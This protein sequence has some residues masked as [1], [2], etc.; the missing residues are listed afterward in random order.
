MKTT[1]QF[2][3]QVGALTMLS[4]ILAFASM[5]VG[6]LAVEFDFDTFA[7][8]SSMLRFSHNHALVKGSMLLDMFGYYLLLTPV[9]FYFHRYLSRKTLWANT[10]TFCG[11]SYIL[12][13]SIGAAILA[14]VWPQQMQ[15]YLT[16]NVAQ[17]AV[18]QA[19]A[20]NIAAIV[21]GGMWNILETFLCG[22]WW[23]GLGV[24]LRTELKSPGNVSI[25]LGVACLLDSVGNM[26]GLKM[27]AE[28]GLNIYL[29]FAIVW[30]MWVGILIYKQKITA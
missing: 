13:G 21:Y 3:R 15:A 4:A 7:D 18:L 16:A 23:V 19:D 10:L 2:N 20:S 1:S 29:F 25:A 9:A 22:V 17:Q 5:L 24:A 26:A 12:I 28:I 11:L 6:T 30:A 27:L 14:S 8:P